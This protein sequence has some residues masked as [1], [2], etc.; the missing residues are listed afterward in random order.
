MRGAA[1]LLTAAS[2][3]IFLG[4]HLA[5]LAWFG[6]LIA[7]GAVISFALP[8]SGVRLRDHPDRA[9][10]GWALATAIGVSLYNVADARGVR[11][12]PNPFSFIVWLFLIDC[13][14]ISTT[15]LVLRRRALFATIGGKWRYGV[16]AG[17]LSIASFGSALYAFT[18]M[19]TA[20]VSALRETSVVFAALF[21]GAILK[22]SLGRRRTI[23]ACALA[24]GLVLMQFGG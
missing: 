1:P 4:E 9:A 22:E 8:P 15:A 6:L 11:I 7:T 10:L 20:K 2:A 13:V 5:P 16:A 3:M 17:A 14:C 24:G 12:A 21:G 18:L 23:A 19:A